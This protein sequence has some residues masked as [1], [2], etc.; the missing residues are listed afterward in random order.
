MG[1][2]AAGAPAMAVHDDPKDRAPSFN[3]VRVAV[4]KGSNHDDV[5]HT[6]LQNKI[7]SYCLADDELLVEI[8]LRPI[9]PADLASITLSYP[10]FI[11]TEFP[12]VPGLE[13]ILW[14]PKVV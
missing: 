1:Q 7:T 3:N 12:A 13:G 2:S 14:K 10:G 9:H 6:E 5:P 8:F 4:V 11:P